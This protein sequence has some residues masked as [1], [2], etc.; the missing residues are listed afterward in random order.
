[1]RKTV[2]IFLIIASS[3]LLTYASPNYPAITDSTEQT[4]N[5][6]KNN[7]LFIEIAGNGLGLSINY[8]RYISDN[9]SV[10]V[11]WGNDIFKSTYVPLLFNYNFEL[12]WELG[13]G[14]VT[15][16][17]H[18]GYRNDRIF[19]SKSSGILLTSVAGFKKQFKRFLLKISFT[20]LYN[21]DGSVF[22]FFGGVSAGIAF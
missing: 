2:T 22:Q 10:R 9:L 5:P 18:L 1:M 19:A 20:P 3:S 4:K 12:P 17:F 13:I 7:L 8:E 14:I 16:N 11:G 6:T 15:Y 21:P